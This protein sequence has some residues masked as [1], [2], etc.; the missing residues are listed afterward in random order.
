LSHFHATWKLSIWPIKFSC[1]PVISCR[2]FDNYSY[3][4]QVQ[5]AISHMDISKI[6]ISCIKIK[7]NTTSY[8]LFLILVK[9]FPTKNA[10][11]APYCNL[12]WWR[13]LYNKINTIFYNEINR[14]CFWQ[15]HI[16][17]LRQNGNMKNMYT[18]LVWTTLRDLGPSVCPVGPDP[19]DC[20]WQFVYYIG[21]HT[22]FLK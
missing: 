19:P 3:F 17:W 9:S 1:T 7:N 21:I 12:R 8:F 10:V 14:I 2:P 13:T 15:H 18:R 16:S 20:F 11:I 5:M 4:V 22:P 6:V